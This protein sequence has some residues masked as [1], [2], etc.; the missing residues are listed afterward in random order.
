MGGMVQVPFGHTQVSRILPAMP[1]ASYKTYSM[2]MPLATH[3]R[4]ASCA[5]VDCDAYRNG[6]VSTFDIS[7]DLGQKQHDY[8]SHDR[9]RGFSTQRVGPALVKFIYPPGNRCFQAG[10]HRVPLQRP[11]RY[12]VT[13]GDWRGNPRGVPPRV[14][15]RAEDWIED[16]ATHQDKIATAISNG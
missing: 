14:H 8:C 3:W 6:W 9:T 11:A 2:A 5:E 10:D 15:K 13:G 1:A 4:P 16:F 7:T 12:L